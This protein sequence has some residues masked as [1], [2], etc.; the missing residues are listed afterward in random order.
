MGSN[1]ICAV[2]GTGF[3]SE[4]HFIVIYYSTIMPFY[5]IWARECAKYEKVIHCSFPV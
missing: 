5:H 2:S 4:F 3:F 1:P